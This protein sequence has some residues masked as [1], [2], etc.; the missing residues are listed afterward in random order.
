MYSLLRC[1][2]FGKVLINRHIYSCLTQNRII[3]HFL[4][5]TS[6]WLG[7]ALILSSGPPKSGWGW[8]KWRA[9]G[10]NCLDRRHEC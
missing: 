6:V 8:H 2:C 9:V 10:S 3:H 5:K 7:S 4:H 1:D